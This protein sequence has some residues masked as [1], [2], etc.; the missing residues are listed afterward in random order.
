MWASPE[1]C[2]P[3]LCTEAISQ[4]LGLEPARSAAP[5]RLSFKQ[6]VPPLQS[7]NCR[8]TKQRGGRGLNYVE[9]NPESYL[10]TFP[11]SWPSFPV[12][13]TLPAA[14]LHYSNTLGFY[15]ISRL[16]KTIKE[17][18]NKATKKKSTDTHQYTKEFLNIWCFV[19]KSS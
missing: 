5:C 12:S 16:H 17:K 2:C 6:H 14:F 1:T 15:K 10:S 8:F 3:V 4:K 18:N 11:P 9:K 13:L 19:D 7:D